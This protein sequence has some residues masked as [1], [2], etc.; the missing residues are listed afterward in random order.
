MGYT[1]RDLISSGVW[2]DP[3]GIKPRGFASKIEVQ[4]HCFEAILVVDGGISFPFND[5]TVAQ[6][7]I[8]PEDALRTVVFTD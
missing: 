8:R 5:G 7:E 1:I 6:L 2:P 3:K 4:S